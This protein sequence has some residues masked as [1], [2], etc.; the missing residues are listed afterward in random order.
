LHL[1]I[2]RGFI[3]ANFEGHPP[4]GW[5]YTGVNPW[6][7]KVPWPRYR[8]HC[9]WPNCTFTSTENTFGVLCH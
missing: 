3:S 7:P 9:V 4:M 8:C 6:S 2:T 1:S 5:S